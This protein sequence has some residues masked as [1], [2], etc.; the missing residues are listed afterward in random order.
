MEFVTAR[1][2]PDAFPA[3][4]LL[5]ADIA[6][7]TTVLGGVACRAG[8]CQQLR[9]NV[10]EAYHLRDQREVG[11]LVESDVEFSDATATHA[12]FQTVGFLSTGLDVVD[13]GVQPLFHLS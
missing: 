1:K 6:I 13:D 7:P 5:E 8:I 10:C 12:D 4:V 2:L 9:Q 3:L 11:Y